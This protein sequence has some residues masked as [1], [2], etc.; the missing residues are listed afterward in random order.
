MFLAPPIWAAPVKVFSDSNKTAQDLK[1]EYLKI[2]QEY[3]NALCS[4]STPEFHQKL[5]KDFQG[6][7]IYLP[8]IDNEKIDLE[9]VE[10]SLPLLEKKVQWLKKRIEELRQ[11]QFKWIVPDQVNSLR[12]DISGLL[13]IK[14]DI[15]FGSKQTTD[16]IHTLQ[17]KLVQD[18]DDLIKEIPFLLNFEFPIDHAQMRIDHDLLAAK[19]DPKSKAD[20]LRIYTYR[21]IY[22]DGAQ[23]LG[24]SNS[25]AAV[26]GLISTLNIRLHTDQVDP[27][28]VISED[29]RY[30]LVSTLSFVENQYKKGKEKIQERMNEWY[31]R[32]L[33][34]LNVYSTLIKK[35]KN[36]HNDNAEELKKIVD[37]AN[38]KRS[39]LKK[40]HLEKMS[41]SYL[42]WSNRPEIFQALFAL[43]TILFNEVGNS[44]LKS[45]S[46]RK[47]IIQVVFNRKQL[48]SYSTLDPN[49]A[50]YGILKEKPLDSLLKSSWI[51]VL[52]KE[53]E[54]SFTY[55]F[56][57]AASNVYCPDMA[58]VGKRLREENLKLILN[59]MQLPN[60]DFKAIRY[61]SR[62]SMFARINMA[63]I[64]TG[65]EQE[66]EKQGDY[67][68]GVQSL[69]KDFIH[70]K[71]NYLYSFQNDSSRTF[72]VL[73]FQSES[74][75]GPVVMSYFGN[76]PIFFEHRNPHLFRFF[77]A[78]HL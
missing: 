72:H 49:D 33:R 66:Q 16:A 29:N 18:F 77:S 56:L 41:S 1:E 58:F 19:T 38:S 51:N 65:F 31:Q 61:F 28:N 4:P 15:A 20:K 39:A 74:H 26:R 27:K 35:Y 37:E 3:F 6:D 70:E 50:L 2:H 54:F 36:V 34:T 62:H 46:F 22:E 24:S 57:K 64:W 48:D 76:R 78:S 8:F 45:G 9:I 44:D 7:G 60:Y 17:L 52:F 59:M 73:D 30:D 47:D 12:E 5:F 13:K 14:Q 68:V 75:Q 23:D 32:S 67:L 10:A 40:F 42:F 63:P 53:G 71:F 25:D 21:K 11:N 69:K 43:E 55:Y